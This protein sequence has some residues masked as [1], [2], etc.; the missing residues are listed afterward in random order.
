MQSSGIAWTD[1]ARMIKEEKKAGNPLANLIYKLNLEKNQVTLILDAATEE[2]SDVFANFD[3][4]VR[5]DID[6][7]ISA[8]MN[9]RKYFEIKKKS[10]EKEQKTKTAAN[11]A[12]QDAEKNAVKEI[13]KHRQ[14]QQKT[15]EKIRKIFWFEKF[16]WFISS[17]NYLIISGKN[18]QQNESLVKKYMN[19]GDLFMHT[20]MPGAAVT[21]IKNPSGQPVPP[22]TLNEAA[23]FEVCHSRAWE[24]KIITEVYWVQADQVSKTPP[25][26]LYISTGSFIIR[27][28]RNFITPAKLEL[29]FTLMFSLSPECI[30]NH[31][32]ERKPRNQ[33]Q[34]EDED[35][36]VEVKQHATS[37]ANP[38]E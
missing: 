35:E 5:I 28:K 7:H 25:T 26:G 16:D 36:T 34:N 2:E 33:M 19:K 15:G 20:D 31:V 24:A 17:E 37:D 32:G 9:I 27:G 13:V 12:I 8:Q 14:Q 38:Q 18:A 3:P 29:G 1:I 10:Y 21:I 23:V 30:A 4:V 22:I 6:L 11:A